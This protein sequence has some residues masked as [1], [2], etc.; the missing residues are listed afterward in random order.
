MHAMKWKSK[1]L[2]ELNFLTMFLLTARNCKEILARFTNQR[3]N[4]K[5]LYTTQGTNFF[6]FLLCG[7]ELQGLDLNRNSGRR[8]V[9]VIG[10]HAIIPFCHSKKI[11][12][13]IRIQTHS[14]IRIERGSNREWYFMIFRLTLISLPHLKKYYQWRLWSM[15]W[16][17][18]I[19]QFLCFVKE[20]VILYFVS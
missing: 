19:L 4:Q 11:T 10:L 13:W 15:C 1:V 6:W 2:I 17:E 14:R 8:Q 12:S 18:F 3:G 9:N 20:K 5:F 7:S 16:I